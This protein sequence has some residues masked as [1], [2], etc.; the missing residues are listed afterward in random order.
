MRLQVKAH[1]GHVP[2]R[3][4]AYAE[5]RLA[6]LDRRLYEGTLVEVTLERLNNP[7]IREDHV[8]DGVVHTK[9]SNI[10][11]RESAETY[12]AAID[13]L[14]DKLERQ[15]ERY[16]DKR[17][18]EPRRASQRAGKGAEPVPEMAVETEAETESGEEAA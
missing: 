7:S 2:D 18:H 3:V 5:K 13:R 4:R 9:G 10:V 12:E 11:A 1:R 14:V 17:T 8:A 6:K 16:R 15:I